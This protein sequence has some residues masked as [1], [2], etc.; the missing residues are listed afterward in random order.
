MYV[1]IHCSGA[2]H[3]T[4]KIHSNRKKKETVTCWILKK[5]V[6]SYSKRLLKYSSFYFN[7]HEARFSLHALPKHIITDW[8]QKQMWESSCFLLSH[9]LKNC[10]EHVKQSNNCS[11][12]Y[13]KMQL[14]FIK[15]IIVFNAFI[16]CS[17]AQL[18]PALW[19]P[20]DCSMSGFPVLHHLSELAQT[21][22]HWVDNAIQPSRPLSSPSPAFNL[23]QSQGHF[24]WVSSSHQEARVLELQLQHQ[25]LQWI[26][27]IDFL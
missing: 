1:P 26:F 6:H 10:V 21:H 9:T 22:I 16:C 13:F 7:W 12:L 18:Y 15:N 2:G 23:S 17:I 27:R 19:N 4:H 20:M 3:L 14:L 11:F 24:Q 5:N 8:K 25:S